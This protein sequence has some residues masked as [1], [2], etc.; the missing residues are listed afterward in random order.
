MEHTNRHGFIFII[1][2]GFIIRQ[3]RIL[4]SRTNCSDEEYINTNLLDDTGKRLLLKE[5]A[6]N[7]TVPEPYHRASKRKISED[8]NTEEIKTKI[9][10]TVDFPNNL[11]SLLDSRSS[12]NSNK[13]DVSTSR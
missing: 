3:Y 9:L 13:D 6:Q 1:V 10:R 2:V 7:S 5:T 4:F 8:S 11:N 12:F